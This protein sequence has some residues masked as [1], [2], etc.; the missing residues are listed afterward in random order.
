MIFFFGRIGLFCLILLVSSQYFQIQF[1]R[2]PEPTPFSGDYF[3]NPYDSLNGRWYKANFHA[4]AHAWGGI[5]NGHQSGEEI[6]SLYRKMGYDLPYLSDYFSIND[7]QP[8]HEKR[9]MPVYEHG[10]NIHKSHRLAIGS[11]DVDFF[12]VM[13]FQNQDIRQYLIKRLKQTTPVVCINHPSMK[14]SHPQKMMRYLSGYECLEVLNS[15]RVATNHWD[16]ALS[17]GKPVWIL[18]NDDCHDLR[19]DHKI[20]KSWTMVQAPND[21]RASILEALKLG[22]T[23]GVKR[24]N[25]TMP[26]A[27]LLGEDWRRKSLNVLTSM[28]VTHDTLRVNLTKE[29]DTVRLMGQGGEVRWQAEQV[30][31]IEY[32]IQMED[33][34]LRVEA[35][36][37]DMAYYFNPIVRYNGVRHPENVLQARVKFWPTFLLR[38]GIIYSNL[39][40]ALLLFRPY[41]KT[42]FKPATAPDPVSQLR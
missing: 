22:R 36:T 16:E 26:R 30:S 1:F 5:T 15:F 32:P 17:A 19:K 39:F 20:S 18:A 35:S 31:Y 10:I 13:L 23:Y 28:Q 38:L 21:D 24:L 11:E 33:T 37:S 34:Y 29:M 8:W 6:Q 42:I 25:D 3:Y 9:F 12:D 40:I 14:H 7:Q 41:A 2:Y 4:H 27:Q